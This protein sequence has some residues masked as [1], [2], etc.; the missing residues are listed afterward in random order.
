M[1]RL[2]QEQLD[3][4]ERL[5][6][7]RKKFLEADIRREVEMSDEYARLSSEAPDPGDHSVAT[8][9]TDL[10]NAVVGRDIHEIREIDAA[11]ERL[12]DGSYGLCVDCGGEIPYERLEV[13]PAAT[14]CAPCQNQYEKTYAGAGRGTSL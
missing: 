3:H 8:L 5:L 1:A 4:L 14:R 10:N 2:T 12:R 9:V 6:V 11:R 13:Q 7:A